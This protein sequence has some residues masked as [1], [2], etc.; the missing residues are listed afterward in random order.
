MTISIA[1]KVQIGFSLAVAI[2][3][4]LSSGA[5]LMYNHLL[6]AHA[7]FF[8]GGLG[9]T[10]FVL[11]LGGKV[12]SSQQPAS[13]NPLA[14]LGTAKHWGLL[15]LVSAGLVYAFSA[16]RHHHVVRP[17]A[18]VVAPPK[19]VVEAPPPVVHFPP[20]KLQ[21]IVFQ[22]ERS[23]ALI[24]GKVVSIGEDVDLVQV[25]AIQADHV[26]VAFQGQTNELTV[27]DATH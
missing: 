9:L 25:V 2:L 7:E 4:T 10:G 5:L 20:M 15:V 27:G 19:P 3:L 21:S 22:G 6:G 18:P 13:E 14:C 17:P 12:S 23:T 24:N 26:T 8:C 11:W 1:T 16:Y